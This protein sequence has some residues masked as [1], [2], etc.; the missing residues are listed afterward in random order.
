MA[1]RTA[2]FLSTFGTPP[3]INSCNSFIDIN[4]GQLDWTAPDEKGGDPADPA[5]Q[6]DWDLLEDLA[7]WTEAEDT[8]ASTQHRILGGG[9]MRLAGVFMI[10][11]GNEVTIGGTGDQYVEN[12]Q[13]VARRLTVAGTGTMT[14]KPDPADSFVVPI[15][16]GFQ[17][18]R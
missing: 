5:D 18:V 3:T 1:R 9:G 14:M 12:S 2:A 17:L 4:G 11:N 8:A 15:I 10:P 6:A 7:L 16:G 13:Y